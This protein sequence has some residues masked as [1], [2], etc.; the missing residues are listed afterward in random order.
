MVV[1]VFDDGNAMFEGEGRQALAT[2]SG[3]DG[4]RWKL[5]VRRDVDG[6]YLAPTQERCEGVDIETLVVD[7]QRHELGTGKA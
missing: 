1:V 3:H 6:A 4:V 5:M 2:P 7:G